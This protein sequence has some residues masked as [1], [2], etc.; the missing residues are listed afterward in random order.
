MASIKEA[1]ASH[2]LADV[3]VRRYV[4]SRVYHMTAPPTVGFPRVTYQVISQNRWRHYTDAAGLLDS[5]LQVD[6]WA[7]T[8]GEAEDVA[9][10][11]RDSLDHTEHTDIGVGPNTMAVKRAFLVDSHDDYEA[12]RDGAGKGIFRVLQTWDITHTES[13]PQRGV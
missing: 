13:L 7:R 2:L 3:G 12:P 5:Q 8:S 9:E 6:C 11:V 10:A 1:L 4:D